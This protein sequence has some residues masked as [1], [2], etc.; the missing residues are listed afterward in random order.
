MEVKICL[1]TSTDN[2]QETDEHVTFLKKK[3]GNK[4]GKLMLLLLP[5]LPAHNRWPVI[6]ATYLQP[7]E[8]FQIALFTNPKI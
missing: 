8:V 4:K 1:V 3:K 7:K 2:S 6:S 5:W